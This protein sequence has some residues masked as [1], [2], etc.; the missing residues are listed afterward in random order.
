MLKSVGYFSLSSL[1]YLRIFPLNPG[2]FIF[3]YVTFDL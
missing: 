3:R 1:D 2:K